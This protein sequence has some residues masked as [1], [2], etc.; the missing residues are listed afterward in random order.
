MRNDQVVTIRRLD[1]RP[2][3]YLIDRIELEF[4]LDPETT[5]VTSTLTVRSN[6]AASSPAGTSRPPLLL[7]G[8]DL[9]LIGVEIDGQPSAYELADGCL[10]LAAPSDR[11]TVRVRNN[12][13]PAHNTELIG[14]YVSHGSF[15]TQCEAEGFRRITFFPDRPDV[16]ATYGVTLRAAREAFPVLLSNGNLVGQ[17]Q[18]PD[19]RHW[20][21]WDD[22][23][24]KPSYLFAL[25]AGRFVCA[26]EKLRTRSGRDVLL[27]VW[28]EPGQLDKVGHAMESLKR[29]IRWDEE[30]FGLE[31]DLDRF[32]IVASHDFNMGAMENKG[33]NIFNA[34]YVLAHP[35]IA[36]DADYAHIES[37]VGHEYFHNW[38]G[39][40][41]TCRDWFQ[42][43]LK[44]GLTVFRDQE[45]SADMALGDSGAHGDS[46][47]WARAV[48]RIEDVRTLRAAQFPE[49]AGPMAHPVRPDSYQ[50]IGNF[51]TATVY[52]KGA[53]IVRMLQTLL[54]RDGFRRGL[55]LYFERHDGQAVTCDD[56]VAAMADANE[57]DLSQFSRWYAQAGTPRV[58]VSTRY[59]QSR[60]VYEVT[61][62]QSCAPS[63]GQRDKAPYLIP[64]ALGLVANDGADLPL[65]L[66]GE[67]QA[68]AAGTRVLE[69]TEPTQTFRFVDIKSPPVPSLGRDFSA[70]VIVDYRYSDAELAFLAAY[71]G[72][73]FN[74]WEAG[75]R[76][77]VSRLLAAI[78]AFELQRMP[79]LD[80]AL[81]DVY[82]RLLAD[83]TLAPAFKEQALQLPAESFLAESRAVIDPDAIRAA[84]QFVRREIGRRLTVAL[85]NIVETFVSSDPYSPDTVAAG[86]RALRN[87]A[88]GYLIDS[89]SS[90][91]L[92]RAQ[93]QLEAAG[94]MT[95]RLAA[96]TAIV[97]SPAAYKVDALLRFAR[98]WQHEPL[99]MNK[100]FHVQATALGQPGEPP[101]L[102][103]VRMLLKHPCFALSN[104]N[105]VYALILG[106]TNHNPAEFHRTDGSGYAF[107]LD[108]VLQ[109]DHLNP[110]V[111]ARTARALDRWR[112]FTPDRSRLMQDALHE[113][114]RAPDLSRDV[115]EIVT[116]ALEN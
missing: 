81:I 14:L 113:L 50:E 4:D 79:Q 103:R 96:L 56:F 104:P 46:G 39:N 7:D 63:P 49:D 53:E 62:A 51:Y 45:F 44:E 25:V 86:R 84:R 70:P 35:A 115:R 61:L 71:D 69:L 15:F 90:D 98:D 10:T 94:N 22:P 68:P 92:D 13:A 12:L 24:P 38:T 108:M 42:L 87:L 30:R 52:E 58:S 74:R 82:R 109:L 26:E 107:W 76:L 19:R 75:Q 59:D 100:W 80:D 112:K 88:L 37:I 40:R 85:H 114:A 23:F 1:Y 16:M 2:P 66:E 95:D 54:G 64:F 5:A 8:E 67:A 97:N 31:L 21:R 36:T 41:V 3:A 99:V 60:R 18:L 89:G 28:V 11:F 111:A 33:L 43:S 55:A 93:I 6:P 101:V 91:A 32:M 57:R 73:G 29:A 47:A 78:D 106:F 48:K 27:Q 9:Q 65:R 105:N 110:T 72:D 83:Q 116:K 17:G 77:A 34:K 102:A 20:A